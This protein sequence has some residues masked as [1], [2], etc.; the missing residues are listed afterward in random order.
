MDSIKA[1]PKFTVFFVFLMLLEIAGLTVIPTFHMVSKALIMAGL[2]GFYISEEKRQSNA[3]LTGLIFALLGDCFLLFSTEQFFMIGLVCFLV[4]QVCYM[5]AFNRKR[6]IP[7]NK[8][9]LISGG[10]A[11]LGI[12]ITAFLWTDLGD[13]K[14]PVSIYAASIIGMAIYAYLRHP[15]LR[16]YSSILVGVVL[17]ILSDSLLAVNKFGGEIPYGQIAVMITYMLAQYFI[18]TGQVLG[19]IPR[20]RVKVETNSTFGRHK[21]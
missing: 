12:L 18:V 16:G 3:F 19:N 4:M 15:L 1:F 20:E 9:Y 21:L 6:R 8:D 11:I 7:K 10:I 14:L 2:I 13:L 17:F 5:T